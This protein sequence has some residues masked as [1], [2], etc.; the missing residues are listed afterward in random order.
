MNP[1]HK[2]PLFERLTHNARWPSLRVCLWLTGVLAALGVAISVAS[3]LTLPSVEAKAAQNCSPSGFPMP[4]ASDIHDIYISLLITMVSLVVP[5]IVGIAAAIQTSRDV[6]TE[7]YDLLRLTSLTK[8]QIVH[9]YLYAGLHR[10]RLPLA[11]TIGIAPALIGRFLYG[12]LKLTIWSATY[13]SSI[14]LVPYHLTLLDIIGPLVVITVVEI[15]L[16]ALNP[17]AAAVGVALSLWWRKTVAAVL[18]TSAIM[19]LGVFFVVSLQI[20]MGPFTHAEPFSLSPTALLEV[21]IASGF[22]LLP[23]VLLTLGSMWLA[24]RRV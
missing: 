3:L 6:H 1:P 20:L 23:P 7:A 9:G 16:L 19:L 2:N 14:A 15:G 17:L 13:C 12:I 24:K 18:F 21:L 11:L 10:M 4:S 22:C 5:P 8:M